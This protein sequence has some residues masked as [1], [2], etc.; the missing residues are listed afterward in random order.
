MA[1]SDGPGTDLQN[2]WKCMHPSVVNVNYV[3]KVDYVINLFVSR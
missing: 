2:F 3:V 1:A